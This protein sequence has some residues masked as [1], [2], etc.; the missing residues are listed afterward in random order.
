MDNPQSDNHDRQGEAVPPINS[1]EK[2]V[3]NLPKGR[4]ITPWVVWREML[5]ANTMV[6]RNAKRVFL[7]ELGI[8]LKHGMPMDQA[9]ETMF[10][11]RGK[12]QG[13]RFLKD[14]SNNRTGFYFIIIMIIIIS[15]YLV[16]YYNPNSDGET[17]AYTIF[18]WFSTSLKSVVITTGILLTVCPILFVALFSGSAHGVLRISRILSRTLHP[19]VSAGVPLSQAL[20][21]RW[22]SVFTKQDI[23][24]IR[25]AEENGSL[26]ETLLQLSGDNY[27]GMAN[28]DAITKQLIYPLIIGTVVYTVSAFISIRIAPNMVDIKHQIM[29]DDTV[30]HFESPALFLPLFIPLAILL[31]IYI[32]RWVLTGNTYIKWL[33]GITLTFD[34]TWGLFSDVTD[35]LKSFERYFQFGDLG[36]AGLSI[37]IPL[38]AIFL[39]ALLVVYLMLAFEF[40]I[41]KFD[42]L[43]GWIWSKL[44]LTSLWSKYR[45]RKNWMN[46]M[47]RA[48][49]DAVPLPLALA[50]SRAVVS[51]RTAKKLS[52]V[53]QR[54]Q[55][56]VPLGRACRDVN[57]FSKYINGRLAA[58]DGSVVYQEAF[59]ELTDEVDTEANIRMQSFI[60]IISILTPI[61]MGAAVFYVAYFIYYDLFSFVR[62]IDFELR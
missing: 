19:F 26:P 32:N 41:R 54:I 10:Q 6:R 34:L 20:K 7:R 3:P 61:L 62:Y 59:N 4:S 1:P 50:N 47:N 37:A 53:Q 36:H 18:D 48:V 33:I 22:K 44:P 21:K 43:I 11:T 24:R 5:F 16:Y 9:L 8:C 42:S 17:Y 31:K 30:N 56:G 23:E 38:I 45:D 52:V 25:I 15:S 46:S 12:T 60:K 29:Q 28:E 14:R 35:P 40:V 58:I 55:Q 13:A 39:I 2:P 27:N 51:N 49:R 57:L